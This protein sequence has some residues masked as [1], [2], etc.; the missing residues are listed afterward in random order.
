MDDDGS[1]QV[2]DFIV[3]ASG[4][5]MTD[6]GISDGDHCL[7]RP[8]PD[9]FNGTIALVGIE[10]GSTIKRYYKG[11]D[12]HRLVPCNSDYSEM[13]YPKDADVRIKG[14]F[15]KTVSIHSEQ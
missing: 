14:R 10:N 12:G 3:I 4:D 13:H 1:V 2:G 9:I 5:S 15:I 6:A 8:N 11:K 7:I